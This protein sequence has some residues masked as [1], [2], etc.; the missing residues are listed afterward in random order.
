MKRDF[1]TQLVYARKLP[2]IG[3]LAYLLL[4]L[5]GA[6]IPPSVVIG[7]EFLIH[8]G[9]FGIVVHSKTRIGNRVR[10]YPGVTIG[11][12][13]VY[14]AANES[15]FEAVYIEDDVILGSGAKVLG[16]KGILRIGKGT[17]VGAN[18]V[19]LQST[20]EDEIWTGMPARCIGTRPAHLTSVKSG[21]R[22]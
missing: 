15:E 14:L 9:G 11:R 20:G 1:Y 12:A 13:D 10:I 18:S 7:D 17:V 3:K 5:L 16:K 4:K 19:L 22:E 21:S 6:E 8:H 2:L